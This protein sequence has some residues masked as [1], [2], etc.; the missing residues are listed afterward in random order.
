[1]QEPNSLRIVLVGKHGS[2]KSS[3]ANCILGEAVF[4]VSHGSDA[5]IRRSEARSKFMNGRSV[6]VIDTPGVLGTERLDTQRRCEWMSRWVQCAP[7]PHAVLLVMPVQR[8]TRQERAVVEHLKTQFGEEVFRFTTV[9]FTHGDQLPENMRISEFVEQSA[10]L[11][12]LVQ[13][14][15]GRCHVVDHKYWTKEAPEGDPQRS[16]AFQVNTILASVEKTARDNQTYFSNDVLERVER[17]IQTEQSRIGSIQSGLSLEESREQAKNSILDKYIDEEERQLPYLKYVAVIT[18]GIAGVIAV[19]V[20]P[21][22]MVPFGSAVVPMDPPAVLAT[23]Q[24]V[25]QNVV[26]PVVQNV[27]EPVVQNVVDPVVQNV[28]DPVVQNVV[29]PV[30]QNVVPTVMSVL[31]SILPK[32]E[33]LFEIYDPF[34]I[35]YW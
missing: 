17:E 21:K 10:G 24:E 16:N 15:G 11:A 8:F 35:F 32:P 19:F 34:N 28:V 5:T 25:V 20:V 22:M 2:G 31:E 9:V 13:A 26:D 30:V 18:A 3:L 27:V 7:G 14:C 4:S 1:M 12:E 6:A 29:D 33:D 23:V